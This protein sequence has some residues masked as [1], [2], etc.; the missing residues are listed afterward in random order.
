[1][2]L[3]DHKGYVIL[4]RNWKFSEDIKILKSWNYYVFISMYANTCI[5]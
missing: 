2:N 3:D 5:T 4:A 1:M